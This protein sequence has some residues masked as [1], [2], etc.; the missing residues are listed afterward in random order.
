MRR[1]YLLNQGGPLET[2]IDCSITRKPVI[3]PTKRRNIISLSS[4]D[5]NEDESPGDLDI[6]LRHASL[7]PPPIV[8]QEAL[9][10]AMAVISEHVQN[11]R[12]RTQQQASTTATTNDFSEPESRT[13]VEDEF[14]L[15]KYQAKMNSEI[16]KQAAQLTRKVDDSVEPILLV[17]RGLK[18]GEEEIPENWETPIGMK[19]KSSTTFAK[20]REE[21]ANK[22]NYKGDI[23]LSFKGVR[24]LH[25]TPKDIAISKEECLG[26]PSFYLC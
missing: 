4:D 3:R 25:G 22:K 5:E 18:I 2:N 24:L 14:D 21:F 26:I 10:Q 12:P 11:N 1:R 8:G 13:D 19:V 6:P 16:A 7:T 23:V 17:M 15:E 20:M 9:R